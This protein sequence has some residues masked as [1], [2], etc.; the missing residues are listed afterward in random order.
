MTAYYQNQIVSTNNHN[1]TTSITVFSNKVNQLN[2]TTSQRVSDNCTENV[3]RRLSMQ[4]SRDNPAKVYC[5]CLFDESNDNEH[6]QEYLFKGDNVS[7]LVSSAV[8]EGGKT[9]A[10]SFY[11]EATV[12]EDTGSDVGL[13]V[14]SSP[15]VNG[16]NSGYIV[17]KDRNEYIDIRWVNALSGNLALKE[18]EHL[19]SPL[20]L[21]TRKNKERMGSGDI[22]IE[23]EFK[24][25]ANAILALWYDDDLYWSSTK[26]EDAKDISSNACFTA[27]YYMTSPD[28]KTEGLV[29]KFSLIPV[30]SKLN[31]CS[32][33]L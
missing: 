15:V 6:T 20:S 12:D 16:H 2:F 29:R 22:I 9:V 3:I 25:E 19:L 7:P 11:I 10:N 1:S 30:R 24:D 33:H 26:P 31:P 27:S 13:I 32:K 18:N 23:D 8:T 28:S 17:N 4:S 5:V 14:H 21:L